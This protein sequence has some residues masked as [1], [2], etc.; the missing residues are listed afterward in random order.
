MQEAAR[1]LR[2]TER[3]IRRRLERGEL[4]GSR[5]P[6]T[7]RWRVEA[8]SV[9][10]AMPDRPPKPASLEGV[11]ETSESAQGYRDRVREAEEKRASLE[12]EWAGWRGGSN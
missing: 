10:E 11:P 6:T 9:T 7:G 1:I 3:T 8:T 2:V 5:D 12:R 4:E